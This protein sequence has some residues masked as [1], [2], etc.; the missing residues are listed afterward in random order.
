MRIK[1]RI[2]VLSLTNID[3]V[4]DAHVLGQLA[5]TIG[6]DIILL[7]RLSPFLLLGH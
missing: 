1:M 7:P 6:A 3:L 5:V 2:F 4:K